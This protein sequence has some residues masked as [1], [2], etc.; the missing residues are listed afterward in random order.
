MRRES[1]TLSLIIQS[2]TYEDGMISKGSEA[3]TTIPF[4]IILE[5]D[6]G[7]HSSLTSVIAHS[8]FH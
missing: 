5:D 3:G 2:L 4:Q 6:E 8:L 7:E 1:S